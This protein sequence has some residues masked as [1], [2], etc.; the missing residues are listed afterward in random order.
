MTAPPGAQDAGASRRG[1]LTPG[2]KAELYEVVLDL[3]GEN[4]YECLTVDAVAARA[5][6]SKATVYRHWSGKAELVAAALRHRPLVGLDD[7]DTGSLR[8]DL[9]AVACRLDEATLARNTALLR[10]ITNAAGVDPAPRR[11]MRVMFADTPAAGLA[12]ILRRAVARG[13]IP[14]DSPALVFVP[15]TLIGAMLAHP[16]I[17]GEPSG[18]GFISDYLE[19]VLLPALSGRTPGVSAPGDTG[20]Q[21]SADRRWV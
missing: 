12:G 14:P 8:G 15:H 3:L 17:R 9:R 2:R 16:L 6:M 20:A 11:A 7:I 5:G 19:Q 1:R 4:G 18:T 21:A 13:E 10:G